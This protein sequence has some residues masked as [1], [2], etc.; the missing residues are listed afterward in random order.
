MCVVLND[1]QYQTAINCAP[2]LCDFGNDL[3]TTYTYNPYGLLTSINTNKQMPNLPI[4]SNLKNERGNDNSNPVNNSILN[5]SYAYNNR[6]L[7]TSRS[8]SV[9]NQF[10][11]FTYDN[12]DRLTGITSGVIGQ[13]GTLQS[14]SY[15]YNG[16]ITHNSKVGSYDYETDNSKPHAVKFITPINDTVIS[17]NKCAV[18]YNFFNQP[19]EIIETDTSTTPTHRLEIFYEISMSF[20]ISTPSAMKIIKYEIYEKLFY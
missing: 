6:G 1:K 16:N 5:Y 8:E 18:T 9:I 15:N 12:L 4:E 10:E 20:K 13:T 7:M 11:T 3:A 17:A 14:F 2:T 19:I